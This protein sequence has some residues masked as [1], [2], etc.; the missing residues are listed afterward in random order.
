[1]DEKKILEISWAV[2]RL[3][4]V[5][6]KRLDDVDTRRIIRLLYDFHLLLTGTQKN[7]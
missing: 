7:G 2:A 4:E 1:M 3:S 5:D 6:L